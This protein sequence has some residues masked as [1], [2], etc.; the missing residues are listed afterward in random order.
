MTL[1]SYL[2]IVSITALLCW[3]AWVFILRTVNPEITN[4]LGFLLFYLSLFLALIGTAAIIGFLVRFI[5]LKQEL[6]FRLVKIAFR[7]S[8]LFAFLIVAIL[9]LLAHDLFTWLNLILLVLGL[10]ILEYFLIS[11]GKGTRNIEHGTYNSGEEDITNSLD[12]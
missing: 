3:G 4:W 2:I 5:F 9:F 6:A 12:N 8:F 11:Y 10:S 7:Q 1:R